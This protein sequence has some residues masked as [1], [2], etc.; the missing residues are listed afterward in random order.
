[1]PAYNR[2]RGLALGMATSTSL[3]ACNS[4]SNCGRF[5]RA[6]PFEHRGLN[7]YCALWLAWPLRQSCWTRR[8]AAA[9]WERGPRENGIQGHVLEVL[10]EK[11]RDL[12]SILTRFKLNLNL[13]STRARE[14]HLEHED[15]TD[16]VFGADSGLSGLVDR[17]IVRAAELIC[18]KLEQDRLS[19][20]HH[21]GLCADWVD[22]RSCQLARALFSP[23]RPLKSA[24][25]IGNFPL[26][27]P[28]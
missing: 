7:T 26:C 27:L 1:M 4:S 11:N 2:R 10:Q 8:R 18:R 9:A 21:N 22:L 23:L 16:A 14:E 17:D 12:N 13:I 24:I 28:S 5:V 15:L 6:T 3:E 19:S 20:E 25:P